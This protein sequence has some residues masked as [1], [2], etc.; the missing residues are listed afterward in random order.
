MLAEHADSLRNQPGYVLEAS[1]GGQMQL[2]IVADSKANIATA[3][4]VVLRIETIDEESAWG[5]SKRPDIGIRSGVKIRL[6]SGELIDDFAPFDGI[7]TSLSAVDKFVVPYYAKMNT[8]EAC[9]A[10]R[11]RFAK[12][13]NA[14]AVLHLP[15]S[16]ALTATL[17]GGP[18][19]M[20]WEGAD[21]LELTKFAYE[22]AEPK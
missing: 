11:K 18:F 3:K 22:L 9:A 16:A 10:A 5:G 4:N 14:V 13:R 17:D 7:F 12:S 8:L 1:V 2:D 6:P 15:K 20:V 19:F 21:G